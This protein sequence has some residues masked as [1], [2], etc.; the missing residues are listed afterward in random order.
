MQSHLRP[1]DRGLFMYTLLPSAS[2][3]KNYLQRDT[4]QEHLNCLR[5][6]N[7][8][9]AVSFAWMMIPKFNFI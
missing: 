7:Q 1:P 9:M 6:T 3:K 5:Y 4:A 2:Q 8:Q